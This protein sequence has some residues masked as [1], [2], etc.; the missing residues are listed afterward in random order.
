MGSLSDVPALTENIH[1]A[2]E[3]GGCLTVPTRRHTSAL[4]ASGCHLVLIR[5]WQMAQRDSE[6][7]Q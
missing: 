3:Q 2:P 5:A 1:G 6:L 4:L 7:E